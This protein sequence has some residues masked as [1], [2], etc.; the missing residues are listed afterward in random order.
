M[1]MP[2]LQ[3]LAYYIEEQAVEVAEAV[4]NGAKVLR[5]LAISERHVPARARAHLL[6]VRRTTRHTRAIHFAEI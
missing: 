6:P 3:R 2:V 1:L 5:R 4:L